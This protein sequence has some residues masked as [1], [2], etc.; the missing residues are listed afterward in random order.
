MRVVAYGHPVVVSRKG[1]LVNSQIHAKIRRMR[2]QGFRLWKIADDT[3][4]KEH[5]VAAI[6]V[7]HRMAQWLHFNRLPEL[8]RPPLK[9]STR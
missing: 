6:L 3:G 8:K 7:K 2:R 1:A 5:V 4:V 9:R